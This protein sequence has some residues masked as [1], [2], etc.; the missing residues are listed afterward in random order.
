MA[1]YDGAAGDDARVRADA[2]AAREA[3]HIALVDALVPLVRAAVRARINILGPLTVAVA[4]ERRTR[5]EA[6]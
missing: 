2:A 3:V 1:A 5:G 6:A 4:E